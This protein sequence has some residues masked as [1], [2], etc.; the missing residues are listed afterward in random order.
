MIPILGSCMQPCVWVFAFPHPSSIKFV[1]IVIQRPSALDNCLLCLGV[2]G[3]L[4]THTSN[5]QIRQAENARATEAQNIIM[6][7]AIM[8]KHKPIEAQACRAMRLS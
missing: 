2:C 1:I 7:A 8:P 4:A 5:V 6:E 3:A